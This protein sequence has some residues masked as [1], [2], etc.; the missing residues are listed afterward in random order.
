[1]VL[2]LK[3]DVLDRLAR[4]LE[5][6]EH[7][8]RLLG[9][10]GRVVVSV[11][12]QDWRTRIGGHPRRRRRRQGRIAGPALTEHALQVTQ[13]SGVLAVGVGVLPDEQRQVGDPG[14]R[15]GA[16]IGLRMQSRAGQS[17]VAAKAGA[18]DADPAGIDQPLRRH[19]GDAV[20]KIGLHLA[21]PLRAASLFEGFSEAP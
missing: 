1:M 2:A 7:H 10:D 14:D 20:Q 15:G 12:Q 9:K 21:T 6:V 5:G 11:D 8:F 16:A 17:R 4:R 19:R 18:H 13:R 3:H